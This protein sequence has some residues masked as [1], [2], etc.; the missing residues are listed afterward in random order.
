MEK[1]GKRPLKLEFDQTTT[2]TVGDVHDMFIREAT[3]YMWRDMPFDKESWDK[4]TP[5]E[6]NAM[7]EHL[8][9]N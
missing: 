3:Q 1:N 2:T 9:V 4:V 8:R 7:M 5:A 6:K